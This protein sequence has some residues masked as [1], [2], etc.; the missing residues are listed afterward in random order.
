MR[1]RTLAIRLL[2]PAILAAATTAAAAGRH[3]PQPFAVV[4]GDTVWSVL[5]PDAIPAVRKPVYLSCRAARARMSPD[6]PVIGVVLD[7][8]AV[9]WSTWHLDRH[10][11][12]DD[13][14]AGTAIAATW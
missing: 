13:V 12:V 5:P 10:E 7:D 2:W 6:E 11:I 8:S 9:C 3:A 1:F 14:L 4:D